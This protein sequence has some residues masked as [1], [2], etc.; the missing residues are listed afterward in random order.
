MTHAIY[1]SELGDDNHP[2]VPAPM[3]ID[4]RIVP[5]DDEVAVNA[6]TFG[7]W[8]TFS[9]LAGAKITDVGMPVQILP[10]DR[11]R[12]QAQVIVQVAAGY[13]L[14]GSRKQVSNGQGGQVPSGRY[15]VASIGE[16]Y[17][18]PDGTNAAT[19]TVLAERD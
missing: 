13:V 19:I 8:M 15:P 7:A 10:L 3:P 1:P 5:P 2:V 17:A 6:A 14:L 16:L 9:W 4:V 18:A 11:N 12:R